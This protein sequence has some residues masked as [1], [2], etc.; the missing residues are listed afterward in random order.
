MYHYQTPHTQND[1]TPK[2]ADLSLFITHQSAKILIYS[3]A[4][5]GTS[6]LILGNGHLPMC[7]VDTVIFINKTKQ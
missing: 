5:L 2:M 6:V 4:I 1:R 3:S 7:Q